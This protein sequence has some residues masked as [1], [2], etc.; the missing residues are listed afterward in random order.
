M[1]AH[2]K[3]RQKS[4]RGSKA[5]IANFLAA[6][7]DR[8]TQTGAFNSSSIRIATHVCG[9]PACNEFLSLYSVCLTM[10]PD[11]FGAI[12]DPARSQQPPSLISAMQR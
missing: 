8:P 12:S 4:L 6:S 9:A 3:A 7:N 10:R 2:R 1:R 11:A 5:P